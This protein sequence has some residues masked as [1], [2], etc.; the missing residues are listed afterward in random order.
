MGNA[1]AFVTRSALSPAPYW[2]LVAVPVRFASDILDFYAKQVIEHVDDH[3][4]DH[5]EDSRP[6]RMDDRSMIRAF[7]V[8]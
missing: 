1:E 5:S 4:R 2:E 3:Q 8:F 6:P 7:E